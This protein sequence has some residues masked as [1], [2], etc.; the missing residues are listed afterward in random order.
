MKT[1]G[2]RKNMKIQKMRESKAEWTVGILHRKIKPYCWDKEV[3]DKIQKK[4]NYT[5]GTSRIK[6]Q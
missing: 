1:E 5:Y 3:E 2:P 4:S 6:L